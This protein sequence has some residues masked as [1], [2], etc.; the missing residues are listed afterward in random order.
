MAQ[1][2]IYP[3]LTINYK[4]RKKTQ[5]KR[6]YKKLST[7]RFKEDIENLNGTEILKTETCNLDT[8]LENLLQVIN[9]LLDRHAPLKQLMKREIKTK[10]KPWL[11]TGFLMSIHIKNKIHDKFCKS[12]DKEKSYYI[13]VQDIEIFLQTLKK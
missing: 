8:S 7:T 9:T 3:E 13:K 5:Y 1:F 4:K 2:L 12:K 10:S 6:N 11:E